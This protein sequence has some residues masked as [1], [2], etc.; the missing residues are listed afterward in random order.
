ML[1]TKSTI[2]RHTLER[3]K[4]ETATAVRPKSTNPKEALST[5]L[6]WPQSSLRLDCSTLSR[7]NEVRNLVDQESG[8]HCV[9]VDIR[10]SIDREVTQLRIG[11]CAVLGKYV[12]VSPAIANDDRTQFFA[13]LERVE[14]F[15]TFNHHRNHPG[16]AAIRH[17]PG[18]GGNARLSCLSFNVSCA[19][20]EVF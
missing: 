6:S 11:Y 3:L 13:K 16:L 7:I 14:T 15:R 18:H 1:A 10:M 2:E 5:L 20:V 12:Y 9:P 17:E 4:F 19:P 8:D